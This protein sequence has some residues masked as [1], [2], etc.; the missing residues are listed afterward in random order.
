MLTIPPRHVRPLADLFAMSEAGRKRLVN[1]IR[2]GPAVL[3]PDIWAEKVGPATE[4]DQERAPHLVGMLLSLYLAREETPLDQF[5]EDLCEAAQGSGNAALRP[6]DGNWDSFKRDLK[7]LLACDHSLGITAKAMDIK[8]RHQNVYRT[9]RILTDIRP[10]FKEELT[11]EPPAS[12]IIHTLGIT[13][14]QAGDL[15]TPK[16]LYFALDTDDLRELKKVV[17]RA[18]RKEAT[19]KAMISR[20]GMGCLDIERQ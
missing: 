10:V 1:V 2:E 15:S 14:Y 17:D 18:F 7:A 4:L 13:T 19:L 5:A 6:K 11:E 12:V 20:T 16:E 8:I 3:D 9:A